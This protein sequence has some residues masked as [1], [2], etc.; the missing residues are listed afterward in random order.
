MSC[1]R[2]CGSPCSPCSP[3]SIQTPCSPCSVGDICDSPCSIYTPS[4]PCSVGD[5]CESPSSIYSPCS[6]W[7]FTN[8]KR[9]APA[10]LPF[11]RGAMPPHSALGK[12]YSEGQV[13]NQLLMK[14]YTEEM[15]RIK[16]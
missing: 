6:P 1:F 8:C 12:Q 9:N 3:D 14:S 13:L 16:Q 7:A 2:S 15:A 11:V 10:G 4:S 5:I